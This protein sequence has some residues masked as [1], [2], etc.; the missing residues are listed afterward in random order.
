[1]EF[2]LLW[3][4]EF[5]HQWDFLHQVSSDGAHHVIE[6]VLSEALAVL[7]QPEGDVVDEWWVFTEGL[8]K[9]KKTE[10]NN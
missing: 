8:K 9:N 7:R 5:I 6:V 2:F 10:E 3:V 1:M 4:Y